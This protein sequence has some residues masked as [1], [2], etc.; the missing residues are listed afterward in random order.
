[1]RHRETGF[2]LVELLVVIAIIGVLIALLLPAVQSAREAARRI[3][4]GNHLKQIA[5]AI[6]AYEDNHGVYPPGRVGY[7]KTSGI[8]EEQ[9]VGTSGFV[10]IL[11]QLGLQATYDLFDFSNGPWLES[12][13]GVGWLPTNREAIAQRPPVFACPSD[14][15]P[16]YSQRTADGVAIDYT[17]TNV[18]VGSYALVE[19]SIGIAVAGS[20]QSL[21]YDNNGVFFYRSN[22]PLKEVT[23]GLSKTMFVGE[24]VDGHTTDGSNIWTR[25]ERD[26]NSLRS[27]YNPL[28]TWPG[29]PAYY[30]VSEWRV[31]GAFASRHPGGANFAFGD[32]RVA[33]VEENVALQIYQAL[34]TRSKD[35]VL[36]ESER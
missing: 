16:L 20:S 11:S 36:V 35:E 22:M 33:F 17:T 15:I 8:T 3:Q 13:L 25:A 10:A 5:L 28:N 4:C 23:D 7:D 31:N 26:H 24:V 34:S 27:T 32:G 2:T 14:A 12:T 30:Q 18:G 21:K 29:E 19:G 9:W 6:A 1:M